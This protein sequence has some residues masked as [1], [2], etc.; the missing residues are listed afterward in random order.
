MWRFPEVSVT[1]S[2]PTFRVCSTPETSGNLHTFTRLS[3]RENFIDI[4]RREYFKSYNIKYSKISPISIRNTMADSF[5]KGEATFWTSVRF[6]GREMRL[7]DA[8]EHFMYEV[9]SNLG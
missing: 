7:G 1:N 8:S 6:L 5:Q 9:S 3:A 4:N 2:V